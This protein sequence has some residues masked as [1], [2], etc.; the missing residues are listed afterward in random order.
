VFSIP[1]VNV[2]E[3]D[4]GFSVEVRGPN[5][6]RYTDGS[7]SADVFSEWLTGEVP[8]VI[9]PKSVKRWN[10]PH[11][12][13]AIDEPVRMRIV[14]NIRRAF[15]FRGVEIDVDGELPPLDAPESETSLK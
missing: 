4:E 13:E 11:S 12:R 2:I 5:C 8:M 6:V 9:Y 15:R 10:P 1:R 3:S 14:E 7:R